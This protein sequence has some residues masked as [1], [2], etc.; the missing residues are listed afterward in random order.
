MAFNRSMG[1]FATFTYN[2]QIQRN[3]FVFKNKNNQYGTRFSN[4]PHI[5][6][7][8]FRT[9]YLVKP[10]IKII[11]TAKLLMLGFTNPLMLATKILS[12]V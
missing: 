8:N 12:C 3:Q 11:L 10:D 9:I 1:I 7:E 2:E 6:F 5:L 4:F